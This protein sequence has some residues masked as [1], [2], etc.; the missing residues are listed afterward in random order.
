MVSF[1]DY[2]GVTGWMMTHERKM[3]HSDNDIH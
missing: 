1:D 2:A 3:V